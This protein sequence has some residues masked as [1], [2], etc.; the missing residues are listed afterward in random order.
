VIPVP[1]TFSG[2]FKADI[3]SRDVGADDREAAGALSIEAVQATERYPISRAADTRPGLR[4]L[5]PAWTTER[6]GDGRRSYTGRLRD[7][8]DRRPRC[9]F[10]TLGAQT[11]SGKTPRLRF[12]DG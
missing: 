5:T 3:A 8:V 4:E 2:A 7:V 12:G 9:I 6:P 11:T 10:W 1:E